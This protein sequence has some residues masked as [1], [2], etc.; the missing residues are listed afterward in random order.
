MLVH[1]LQV[2]S[3]KSTGAYYYPHDFKEIKYF[4]TRVEEYLNLNSHLILLYSLLAVF[5]SPLQLLAFHKRINSI[6]A[7]KAGGCQVIKKSISL[8]I[9]A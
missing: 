2:I 4:V 8:P 3:V 5:K 9:S 1:N 6:G 7:T